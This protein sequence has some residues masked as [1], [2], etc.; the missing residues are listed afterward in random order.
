MTQRGH[1]NHN[2]VKNFLQI[3]EIEGDFPMF[4]TGNSTFLT[5]YCFHSHCT[6]FSV[7]TGMLQIGLFHYCDLIVNLL[8]DWQK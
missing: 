1:E 8:P 2:C 6:R 3:K 7:N 4:L 5:V